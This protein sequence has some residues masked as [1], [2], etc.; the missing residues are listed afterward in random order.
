MC[1]FS[2]SHIHFSTPFPPSYSVVLK[3]LSYGQVYALVCVS[4]AAAAALQLAI[5]AFVYDSPFLSVVW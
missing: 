3:S 5:Q 2:A 4:F 1:T